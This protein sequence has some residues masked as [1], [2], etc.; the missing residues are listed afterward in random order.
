[1]TRLFQVISVFLS[2]HWLWSEWKKS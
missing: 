1:M 2:Y